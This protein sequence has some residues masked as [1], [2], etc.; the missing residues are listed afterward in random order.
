MDWY[1]RRPLLWWAIAALIGTLAGAKD[2]PQLFILPVPGLLSGILL[3]A[4]RRLNCAVLLATT[5][6]CCLGLGY[7]RGLQS[8]STVPPLLKELTRKEVEVIYTGI[9]TEVDSSRSG[10]K[11]L[12]T[13]SLRISEYR[14]DHASVQ[15]WL[16]GDVSAPC[17]G[18]SIRCLT[19]IE[20]FPAARN[21]GEFDYR[22][23]Q[24][25]QGR[26]FQCGVH[27]PWHIRIMP[28]Q[29][30]PLPTR[31]SDLRRAGIRIYRKI[32][33]P[34]AAA[35]A[36]AV[37]FGYRTDLDPDL[38]A[39]YA[40]LGVVHVMAVSGLHVGF[41]ILILISIGN[42]LRLPYGGQVL[43]T[44]AGLLLYCGIVDFRPS[45]V[46]ASVMAAT[47]L[48]ATLF[49]ERYDLLNLLG[50]AALL[51]ILIAPGQVFQLGFQLSFLAVLG[52][53]SLYPVLESYLALIGWEIASSPKPIRWAAG[54]LLV[55]LSASLSTLPI[56]AF[57]FGIVPVLGLIVNLLVIP[58][59]GLIVITLYLSLI[60]SVIWLPAGLLYASLPDTLIGVLNL[61]LHLLNAT[62]LRAM[63]VPGFH[64]YL[65]IP[66][67]LL[68]ALLFV[69]RHRI[70]RWSILLCLVF[71]LD[72]WLFCQPVEPGKCRITM[73]D[74]GQGDAVLVEVPDQ[75]PV[76]IDAGIRTITGDMGERV[77]LPYLQHCGIRSLSVIIISHFDND[78][79]G[80]VPAVL[81]GVR[82]DE[83]WFPSHSTGTPLEREVRSIADSLKIPIRSVAAGFDTVMGG[84]QI[85][86]FAPPRAR[87]MSDENN[88]SIVQKM[89]YG[90]SSVLFT[91]DIE[92]PAESMVALYGDLLR[93]HLI[94]VPHHGSNTSSSQRLIEQVCPEIAMI[95]L[96]KENS[97]GMPS[98]A[99]LRRYTTMGTQTYL[100]MKEGAIILESTDAGWSRVHWR[101]ATDI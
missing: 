9:V 25:R 17:P 75:R 31:M 3:I 58:A 81:T 101:E 27:R 96:A 84:L 97:F 76:L 61:V 53:V 16:P 19:R 82:V 87:G 36:A 79:A 69:W 68:I 32:L 8:V 13:R 42:L 83:L 86:T 6:S 64:G 24:S 21:P 54:L 85:R 74:V 67:Y 70:L 73:L 35:F 1:R 56:T 98:S 41:I 45:V 60:F 37:V 18:D 44:V 71:L 91:G 49:Q 66:F 59:I 28:G 95:S 10:K 26:Y 89:K 72:L 55:S 12:S 7:L 11:Y 2:A 15:V 34:Q 38:I 46:R 99:V 4:G 100:T 30:D 93:A 51:I 22:K 5:L 63:T 33:S 40:S 62:P 23:Y 92:L 80:G 77:I 88:N 94:K 14:I 50:A 57:H 65:T 29:T 20:R 39:A 48:G 90:E 43:F 78:H 47:L 52:I